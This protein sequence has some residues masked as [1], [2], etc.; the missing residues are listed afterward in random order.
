MDSQRD[1]AD[2]ELGL[3]FSVGVKFL[4]KGYRD[5]TGEE[6]ENG[7]ESVEHSVVAT[8]GIQHRA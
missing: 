5:Q 3:L 7:P 8:Q 6:K 1:V 2:V 4:G